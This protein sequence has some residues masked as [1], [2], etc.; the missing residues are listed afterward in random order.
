MQRW[1]VTAGLTVLA[2]AGAVL[3]PRLSAL[4]SPTVDTTPA[5]PP[6]TEGQAPVEPGLSP[7]RV[8]PVAKPLVPATPSG[9]LIVE[10]GLD[11][12]AVLQGRR[13]DRFLTITVTA[14]DDLGQTFRRPVDLSVV[15]DVSGSMSRRGKIDYAKK[16]AKVLAAAMRQGD[17]YSLVTFSDDARAVIPATG[18]AHVGAVHAAIDRI[19]EGG[20]TNL[21]AGV[22]MGGAEIRRTL[23]G[24][25]VGRV[26]VLSDG[27]ANVGRTDTHSL[28]QLV[29]GLSQEGITV[30]TV[31]LG[32]DF[33]EDRLAGLAD[34]GGGSY[35]FVDD[36]GQLQAVFADELE[37]TASVVARRTTLNIDLP[38]GIEGIEVLGWNTK[39]TSSG[40][41]LTLGDIHAGETRKIVARV[42]VTGDSAGTVDVANVQ[43]DYLDLVDG[44][45][46]ESLASAAA[47]VTT[48]A[49][50]V[51]SSW[52]KRRAAA[53]NQAWGNHQLQ[54]SARA[55]ERGDV[56]AAQGL[57]TQSAST[58]RK[59][60]VDFD[61]ASL[62]AEAEEVEQLN[63][64]YGAASPA[65]SAGKR[66]IK[67][68]KE[69]Y[70]DRSR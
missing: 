9:H 46:A 48:D 50:L 17:T 60:A 62:A 54:L 27:K 29:G 14:P 28:S 18:I 15:M 4:L 53:A 12:T 56:A 38:A 55:Y 58:L 31:G 16:A 36:P 37:R 49:S 44:R 30:S 8:D 5:T 45:P 25:N 26:I 11:R 57:A 42:R 65:S 20:S 21:Y 7:V 70:L 51:A 52:D 3:A 41:S 13:E 32:L 59:A 47:T 22:T 10:A 40:W 1:H 61:D 34:V 43:A 33:D 69:W 23:D 68:A 39:R 6:V 63:S 2:V 24:E 35:D 64:G 66:N 67:Q 19:Q